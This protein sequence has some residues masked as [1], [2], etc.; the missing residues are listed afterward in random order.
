MKSF[1]K[2]KKIDMEGLFELNNPVEV[3]LA[4]VSVNF[5]YFG[6]IISG[7]G[8]FYLLTTFLLYFVIFGF[9]M[10]KAHGFL[11]SDSALYKKSDE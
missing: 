11:Y 1:I 7:Q 10:L 4:L 5:L 8:F 6:Q 3:A 9:V 2:I